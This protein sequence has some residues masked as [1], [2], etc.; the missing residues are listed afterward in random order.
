MAAITPAASRVSVVSAIILS[1]VLWLCPARAL[2]WPKDETTDKVTSLLKEIL[3][4]LDAHDDVLPKQKKSGKEEGALSKEYSKRARD[5]T[6]EQ[7]AIQQEIDRR[8]TDPADLQTI[9]DVARWSARRNGRLPMHTKGD[10]EQIALA[11]R[12]KRL[13]ARDSK[14]PKLQKRLDELTEKLYKT[15]TKPTSRGAVYKHRVRKA[16]DLLSRLREE[17]HEGVGSA[18]HRM[19][20][21]SWTTD[22]AE[23]N[24]SV[25]SFT[26]IPD[27]PI[28]GVRAT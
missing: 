9:E 13:V 2:R 15:P 11:K 18:I 17:H 14:S 23:A 12:R 28:W 21:K 3:R 25:N 22:S 19:A 27:W 16:D 1:M 4:W 6:K 10:E 5:L 8:K 20:K 7:R 24:R 26:L